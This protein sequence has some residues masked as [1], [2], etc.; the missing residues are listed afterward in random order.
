MFLI[1]LASALVLAACRSSS[2]NGS[3][4]KDG[5]GGGEPIVIGAPIS[6]TGPLAPYGKFEYQMARFAIEDINKAGGVLGGR[7]LKIVVEDDKSD[8]AANGAAAALKVLD[9]G[10]K[11]ILTDCD[12]DWGAPAMTTAQSK[13]VGSLSF[14]AGAPSFGPKG[15]GPMTHSA[16]MATPNEATVGAEWSYT[17]QNWRSAYLIVDTT[18][19]YDTSYCD[20]YKKRFEQLGGKVVG[21]DQFKQGDSSLASQVTRLKGVNP[22]PDVVVICSYTPGGGTAVRQI[23]A[24]GIDTDLMFSDGLGG[25]TDWLASV[26]N[27]KNAWATTYAAADGSDPIAKINELSQRWETTY[28]SPTPSADTFDGYSAIELIAAAIEKAGSD[29]PKAIAAALSA[30][31]DVTTI[32]GKETFAPGYNISF[33]SPVAIVTV[34]DGKWTFVA[35]QRPEAD[36]IG[37]IVK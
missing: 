20:S 1:A 34:K 5:S 13:G 27:L 4:A 25:P 10:A 32:Y 17:T 23:R 28:G 16:A 9:Q 14:C 21:Q 31:K 2:D 29:D 30:T 18:I 36:A 19:A 37:M 8:Y 12:A 33:T 26:P 24:A 22:A 11:M 7:Q 6:M 15:L 3:P 35:R